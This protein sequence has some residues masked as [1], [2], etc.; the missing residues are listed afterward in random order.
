[1]A[2]PPPIRQPR[3]RVGRRCANWGVGGHGFDQWLGTT[4]W[5]L[6]VGFI[7]GAVAGFLNIAR[8]IVSEQT[9]KKRRVAGDSIAIGREFVRH[10]LFLSL[11][12]DGI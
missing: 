4:P 2:P 11:A 7:F 8:L 12:Y 3:D 9:R 6:L 5:F 1:M 10:R